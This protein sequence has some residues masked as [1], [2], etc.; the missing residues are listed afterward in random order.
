MAAGNTSAPGGWA[1]GAGWRFGRAS[2]GAR[3]I[4]PVTSP[5][6][7]GAVPRDEGFNAGGLNS[8]G[9]PWPVGFKFNGGWVG[10]AEAAGR[11]AAG[12][13]LGR[14]G[15]TSRDEVTSA[16]AGAL[17]GTPGGALKE[18]GWPSARVADVSDSE[19]SEAM[20]PFA[21][22][23]SALFA[24]LASFVSKMPKSNMLPAN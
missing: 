16:S 17:A 15:G 22:S 8:D 6:G 7:P 13:R 3:A 19:V 5:F 20:S 21:V 12:V 18:A 4:E 23:G 9:D 2:A 1:A 10:T 11:G 14:V 24:N